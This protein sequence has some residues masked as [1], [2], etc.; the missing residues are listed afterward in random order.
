MF[1]TVRLAMVILQC[2]FG[3][4]VKLPFLANGGTLLGIALK[5]LS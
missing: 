5:H 3:A 4:L 1:L 2:Y